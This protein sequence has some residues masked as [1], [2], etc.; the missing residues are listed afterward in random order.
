ME[1]FRKSSHTTSQDCNIKQ[2]L[3]KIHKNSYAMIFDREIFYCFG[4]LKSKTNNNKKKAC[5]D[6]Y[7]K[8]NAKQITN[9][10]ML[11]RDSRWHGLVNFFF[12]P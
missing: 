12:N 9:K 2:S 10:F 5:S 6:E 8:L 7:S 3:K 1:T 11:Y 4:L